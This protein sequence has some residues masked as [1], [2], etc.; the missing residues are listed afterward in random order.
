M[1]FQIIGAVLLT[2]ASPT[3]A[4]DKCTTGTPKCCTSLKNGACQ[5]YTAPTSTTGPFLCAAG[6]LG[7]CCT[8]QSGC[9]D[10]E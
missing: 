10:G 4:H 6:S 9:V 1:R 3:L 2:I 8:T 7:Y 5:G